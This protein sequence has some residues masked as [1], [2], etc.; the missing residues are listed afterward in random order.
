MLREI[1][2]EQKQQPDTFHIGGNT[3]NGHCLFMKIFCA[4]VLAAIA[5][6]CP[7]ALAAQ[8][9]VTS[10]GDNGP[11]TLRQALAGA[12]DGDTIAFG[13]NLPATISLTSGELVIDKNLTIS[14]PGA[15]LLTV[16]RAQNASHFRIFHI[17][18][19]HTVI[20]QGLTITNGYINFGF[21][22][23]GGIYND[24][25]NL[26]VNKCII[27]GNSAHSQGG[28]SGGGIGN[29]AGFSGS[30][31]LT[32]NDSIISG[33]N[34]DDG[35]TSN[36]G[37]GI[38]S[39]ALG[40]GTGTVTI[41][42]STISNN[43]ATQGGGLFTDGTNNGHSNV[44]INNC[45]F[46]SNSASFNGGAI[47]T[48]GDENGQAS[49][50]ITNSTFSGNSVGQ[51]SDRCDCNRAAAIWSLGDGGVHSVVELGS[52]VFHTAQQNNITNDGGTLVSHG[53]NLTSDIAVLNINQGSGGFNAPTDLL[54]ANPM[55]DP[56]GPQNNGGPSPTIALLPG[57]PAINSGDPHAPARDQ[58]Y[59][60]R[61]GAPDRGA[62]ESAGTIA[63]LVAVSR[64]THGATGVFDVALPLGGT[65]GIECRTGG[66]NGDHQIAMD[67]ATPMT[68]SSAS[69]TTGIGTVNTATFNGS[70]ITVNLTGVA[71]G[72]QI[73][74]TLSGV[75]DGV[76]TNNV[77]IPISML[78]GD[79]NGN[80][81]V[82]SADISQTKSQSGQA[83][84]IAN[85]REDINVSGSINAS[86]I[87]VVKSRS[88]T[89][90]P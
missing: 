76:N 85:F 14:G 55:L 87:S 84:S 22:A 47:V 59:Y 30:A 37:G 26:T 88:G 10:A 41:N 42:N 38:F 2:C 36:I 28:F 21:V 73:V 16:T 75:T 23:G 32:I 45:T 66:S 44:T 9:S 31:S 67:F 20:I 6:A 24:H 5:S 61:N 18:P 46:S 53:Y 72:Q 49:L 43:R 68:A 11:G 89:S 4:S 48:A 51:S 27:T 79:T 33:N 57:S 17:T 69:V 15:Q 12:H 19:G 71:N 56:A 1:G 83:V 77:S 3:R 8:I 62:F 39:F 63:P 54:N 90:L 64:K 74:L 60:L 80:G 58:R 13:L 34:V 82:N 25:S 78:L 86:D 81:T 52:V 65:A 40:G 7:I 35:V 70:Q 50:V 29:N